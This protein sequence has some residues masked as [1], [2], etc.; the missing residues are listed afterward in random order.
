MTHIRI[1]FGSL[2]FLSFFLSSGANAQSL[3]FQRTDIPTG[4]APQRVAVADFN[5]DGISDIVVLNSSG[6][7]LSV[8]LSNGDGT[9][10]AP[11]NTTLGAYPRDIAVGDVDL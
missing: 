2:A 6:S 10:R 4:T 9:F 8:L 3:S 7:S 1:Q 11:L 5:H